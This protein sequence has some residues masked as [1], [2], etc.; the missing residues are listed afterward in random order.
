MEIYNTLTSKREAFEPENPKHARI[1]VCGPTV[2]D[3][4]HLGHA[5]CYI[6]YDVLVRHLRQRGVEVSY[7]R[8]VTDVDDKIINRAKEKGEDPTLLAA[9]FHRAFSEDMQKLGN[10]EPDIEPKV[11]E[12]LPDIIRLIEGLIAKDHAYEAGGDVYF[13]VPSCADYGKLSHRKQAE[14]QAGASGRIDESEAQRKRHPSD[15]ALWKGSTEA[16]SWPSPWGPGR[17]GWH[18]ECSAMSMRYLGESFDLHGGGL[19]LVFPHHENELAQS[20]CAS[21]KPFARYWMHNGFVQVNSE[22]MS[23]SLGNFF[24]AREVFNLVEPEAIRYALLTTYYRAPFN[25]EWETAADVVSF[26]QFEEAERRLEYLYR[27]FERLAKIPPKRVNKEKTAVPAELGAYAARLSTALDD[28]LNTPHALAHTADFL[29]ALN[30]LCDKA[31]S[32]GGSVPESW[33]EAAK[34]GMQVLTK[35]LGVGATDPQGFLLRVR[36]RRATKAGIDPEVVAA[37]IAARA[38]ARKQKN[39]ALSDSIR[40]ELVKL[41]VELLDNPE[42]T[43]TWRLSTGAP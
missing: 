9:R 41:G 18:I 21:D 42:G 36:D 7:V 30:D 17:P 25:L 11:S 19:D 3:Y 23:K 5:R 2:Y 37:R 29:R 31:E 22:K 35:V 16:P 39:F 6:V 26:P 32:K 4:A 43:T 1:Y 14:L 15:F 33:I 12:H 8:N 28:D 34:T 13:H 24:T 10:H 20:E 27:A 38:E 40:D